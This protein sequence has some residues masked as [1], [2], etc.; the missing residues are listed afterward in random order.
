V[1]DAL[2]V[3]EAAGAIRKKN[4]R[5]VSTRNDEG[6][7]SDRKW[8]EDRRLENQAK[9]ERL[10]ALGQGRRDLERLV[11]RNRG[12]PEQTH[13]PAP[14]VAVWGKCSQ[15]TPGRVTF[16]MEQTGRPL[17]DVE[18]AGFLKFQ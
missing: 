15:L 6:L 1:Y 16:R 17:G 8:V 14:F 13:I 5:V 12:L 4:R 18:V 7:K 10:R 3:L 9:R 11:D 2:N